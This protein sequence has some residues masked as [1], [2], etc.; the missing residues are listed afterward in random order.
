MV[1][2]IPSAGGS[3]SASHQGGWHVVSAGKNVAAVTDGVEVV[4]GGD[5]GAR[6]TLQCLAARPSRLHR[7][8]SGRD[9]GV[10]RTPE[11]V[12]I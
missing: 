11:C 2:G 8:A 3:L 1:S 7:L 12:K 5:E 4:G 9:V 10:G 6:A